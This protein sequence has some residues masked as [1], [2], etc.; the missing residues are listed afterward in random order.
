MR[1]CLRSWANSQTQRNDRYPAVN[2]YFVK[3]HK[4]PGCESSKYTLLY[5][6]PYTTAPLRDYLVSFYSAQGTIELEYLDAQDY[7]LVE[8][9][10]CGMIYQQEIP[11]DFLLHK[12]YEEWI[13]QDESLALVKRRRTVGYFAGLSKEITNVIRYFDRLPSELTFLDFGMGWGQWC[14]MAQA[15]GCTVYGVELSEPRI[16]YARQ[17]GIRV[18]DY[19]EI[20]SMRFD[21]INTEQVFE[22][23][24]EPR[25][26][27][28]H[29]RR[30]LTP[31]GLLKIS[32][33]DGRDIRWRL[34]QGNWQALKTSRYS[35]NPVA[36]LE[37][38]N[39]FNRV[40]LIH[41]AREF[42]L[43]PVNFR[44]FHGKVEGFQMVMDGLRRHWNR[45]QDESL[46]LFFKDNHHLPG[47]LE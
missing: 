45:L 30:S 43:A 10:G 23:L 46:S 29:L 15:Y 22:H 47:I 1:R 25:D 13:D 18:I 3:R 26:T 32:V 21:F 27:F 40:S 5:S 7:V 9:L 2:N 39:C 17:M 8:C 33:P 36:P 35:L 42:S 38:I 12:L 20:S 6:S 28:A 14:R 11:G 16:K 37:H 31:D 4:C 34:N 24:A 19:K 44:V 41:L